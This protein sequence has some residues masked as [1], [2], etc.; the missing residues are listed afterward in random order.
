MEP[1]LSTLGR[2]EEKRYARRFPCL[3]KTSLIVLAPLGVSQ[4]ESIVAVGVCENMGKGGVGVLSDRL[5]PRDVVL[6]TEFSVEGCSAPIPTL[7]K[8]QWLR[9]IEV[10][11]HIQYRMGLQFLI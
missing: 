4:Q 5:I 7:M 8:V 9:T 3:V 6:R 1:F 10:E 11:G 2:V